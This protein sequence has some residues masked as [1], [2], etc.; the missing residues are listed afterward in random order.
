MHGVAH[1]VSVHIEVA[2]SQFLDRTGS[3]VPVDR[4]GLLF[5]A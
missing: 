5:D 3:A 4:C 2:G 1:P